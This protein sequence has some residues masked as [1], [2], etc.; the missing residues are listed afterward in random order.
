MAE[1]ERIAGRVR[2][3]LEEWMESIPGVV[4]YT[5][6]VK[7]YLP[8]CD[9]KCVDAVKRFVSKVNRVFGGST[10]YEAMGCW[11]DDKGETLC[12]PVIVVESGHH[13]TSRDQAD[14]IAKALAE[15]AE[16]AKQQYLAVSQGKFYIFPSKPLIK[17]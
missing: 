14:I 17:R 5:E 16:E 9:G 11:V 2:D 10:N 6:V 3:A 4:C 8:T 12:E 7:F 15:Y 13:C 1:K